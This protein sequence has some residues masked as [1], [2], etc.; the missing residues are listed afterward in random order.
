MT[1]R[2]LGEWDTL[3]RRKRGRRSE[4]TEMGWD[5]GRYYTRSK[6]VNGRVVREYVGG[7]LLGELA[8]QADSRERE[9]RR[10]DALKLRKEKAELQALDAQLK[11]VAE[12]IHLVARAALQAAGFRQH[13]RGEW[14]KRRERG[15]PAEQ[16]RGEVG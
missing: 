6:K 13:K 15:S 3:V 9:H 2:N 14:R 8:A 1:G 11:A 12:T 5:R 16:H 4:V 7:G 10:L